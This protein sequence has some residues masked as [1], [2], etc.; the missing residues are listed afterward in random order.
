MGYDYVMS[1]LVRGVIPK[2]NI[3]LFTKVGAIFNEESGY[4][5]LNGLTDISYEEMRS[6][7][8]AYNPN[9][10]N[11]QQGMLIIMK[12]RTF[13]PANNDI[14]I[15]SPFSGVR[16]CYM[17]G[18]IE[19]INMV[20]GDAQF[21]NLQLA[22][23]WN[24]K[25]TSIQ[26]IIDASKVKEFSQTFDKCWSLV[27]VRLMGLSASVSFKDCARLSNSSILYMINNEKATSP[28]TITLHADVYNRCMAN[29]DILAALQAHTN[30]S[31]ASA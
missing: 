8:N 21:N 30:I 10:W 3:D 2:S 28:I 27:D 13:L 9:P 18:D 11:N 25:L 20:S 26:N 14:I 24:N 6:I 16:L 17:C 22:W 7:Y 1:G 31:L 23:F 15:S 19:T 4:F 5:E 12:V 29:A